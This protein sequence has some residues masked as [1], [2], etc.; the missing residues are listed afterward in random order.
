MLH[1]RKIHLQEHFLFLDHGVITFSPKLSV[2]R[3]TQKMFDTYEVLGMNMRYYMNDVTDS[4]GLHL[5][6]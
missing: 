5:S 6:Q 1:E 4:S 3:G 2:L